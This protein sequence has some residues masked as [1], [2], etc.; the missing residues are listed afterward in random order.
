MA[1]LTAKEI[2]KVKLTGNYEKDRAFLIS[3]SEKM[4]AEGNREGANAAAELVFEIMPDSEKKK[5]ENYVYINGKRLDTY[6]NELR[7]LIKENKKEFNKK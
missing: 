3:E 4:M 7:A 2:L 5:I 1:L 6:Y